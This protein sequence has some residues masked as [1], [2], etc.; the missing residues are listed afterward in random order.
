MSNF[1]HRQKPTSLSRYAVFF[2]FATFLSITSCGRTPN[3]TTVSLS[4]E[5]S[6]AALNEANRFRVVDF[7][8]AMASAHSSC[9]LD[10]GTFPRSIEQMQTIC[11]GTELSDLSSTYVKAARICRDAIVKPAKYVSTTSALDEQVQELNAAPEV[12]VSAAAVQVS[13]PVGWKEE[14]KT[15]I[16]ATEIIEYSPQLLVSPQSLQKTEA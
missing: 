15:A 5:A 4:F 3:A 11:S 1:Q 9:G 16:E 12:T 10:A 7:H 8:R 14:H 13:V 6:A 2:T